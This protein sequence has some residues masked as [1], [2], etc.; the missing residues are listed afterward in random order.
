MSPSLLVAGKYP[1][2]W[3]IMAIGGAAEAAVDAPTSDA[4]VV[5]KVDAIHC[6]REGGCH[7]ATTTEQQ[8]R[9]S[10]LIV[11]VIMIGFW[12]VVLLS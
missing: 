12:F 5:A 4:V 7:A 11:D 8:R 1:N 6:R 3:A 2:S 9:R 10:S